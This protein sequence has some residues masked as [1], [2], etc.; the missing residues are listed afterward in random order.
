MGDGNKKIYKQICALS[1]ALYHLFHHKKLHGLLNQTQS[2]YYQCGKSVY[3]GNQNASAF[4]LCKDHIL[5]LM[6]HTALDIDEI[7]LFTKWCFYKDTINS[8]SKTKYDRQDVISKLNAMDGE[9]KKKFEDVM[10]RLR[11]CIDL[12]QRREIA[13]KNGIPHYYRV[14]QEEQKMS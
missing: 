7:N 4:L 1:P 10:L 6:S 5:L 8:K 13:D 9:K 14:V 3:N 11:C 12:E 2:E